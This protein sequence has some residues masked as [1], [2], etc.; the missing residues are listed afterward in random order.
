MQP[1][2]TACVCEL[3]KSKNAQHWK[4]NGHRANDGFGVLFV[5]AKLLTQTH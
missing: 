1:T 2:F 5:R 3:D 4:I